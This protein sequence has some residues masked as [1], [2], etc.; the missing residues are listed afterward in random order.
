MAGRVDFRDI[1]NKKVDDMEDSFLLP[2]GQYRGLVIGKPEPFQ[3]SQKG[4]PGIR[5]TIEVHE[6]LTAD[7]DMLANAGGLRNKKGD[8]RKVRAEY[9]LTNESEPIF[10]SM[11]ESFFGKGAGLTVG[12]LC[13]QIPGQ[14]CTIDYKH[15]PIEGSDNMRGKVSRMFG[16]AN[17]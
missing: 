5:F 16:T 12:E 4:T 1:M 14:E 7:E 13:E 6:N 15:E 3:S 8:A 11:S 10:K 17:G 2:P 9:Y